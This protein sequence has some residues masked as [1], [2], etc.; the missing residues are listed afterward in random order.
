MA[1]LLSRPAIACIL[2]LSLLSRGRGAEPALPVGPAPS[3]AMFSHFP[4]SV[5][6]VVWRNWH[7]VEPARIAKVLGTSVENVTALAESMGLPPAVPIP[8]EQ[9]SPGQFYMT[10]LRRNWHLLPC[11]QLAVLLDISPE[12]LVEKVVNC[13]HVLDGR[14]R[15]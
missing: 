13:R 9:D 14:A 12:D 8:A 6:A 4:D 3:P 1:M 10:L 7:A 5:H 2:V 11:D 15:R